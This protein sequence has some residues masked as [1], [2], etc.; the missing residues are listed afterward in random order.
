MNGQQILIPV[1]AAEFWQQM[2]SVILEVLSENGVIRRQDC[3][4]ASSKL[5]KTKEVC[6]LFQVS[7][8]TVYDWMEKGMLKS[9]KIESRRFFLASDVE[10]LIANSKHTTT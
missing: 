1:D 2:R 5:L 10:E 6:E 4:T 3:N 8:P 7:K 9:V